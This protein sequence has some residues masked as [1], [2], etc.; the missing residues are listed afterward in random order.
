MTP[1]QLSGQ[2]KTQLTGHP[3]KRVCVK[4]DANTPYATI[5]EALDALGTAGG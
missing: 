4:G 3:G 5:V 1:S 2:V